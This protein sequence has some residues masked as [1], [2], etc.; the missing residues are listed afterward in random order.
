MPCG[1]AFIK[2]RGDGLGFHPLSR[3]AFRFAPGCEP[4][5]REAQCTAAAAE[6]QLQLDGKV[7]PG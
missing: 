4:W 7:Q 5:G 6:A 1:Q 3:A 2:A